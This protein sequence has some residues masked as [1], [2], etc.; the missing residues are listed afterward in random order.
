M[1]KYF[2]M[3]LVLTVTVFFSSC[4]VKTTKSD[5]NS[6]ELL[7]MIESKNKSV[8][9][10]VRDSDNSFEKINYYSS[11]YSYYKS[12]NGFWANKNNDFFV[13]S[14]DIGVDV[15]IFQNNTWESGYTIKITKLQKNEYKTE[16]LKIP[17][18]DNAELLYE[19][20]IENIPEPILDYLITKH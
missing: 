2:I 10:A 6:Y 13:L 11:R 5:N 18:I 14:H 9:F 15:Y 19:Y 20:D 1:K 16:L 7:K 17:V 4:S 3:F 12:T 8:V